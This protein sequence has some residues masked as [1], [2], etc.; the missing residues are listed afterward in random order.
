LIRALQQILQK[1]ESEIGGESE[2]ESMAPSRRLEG[3]RKG[4]IREPRV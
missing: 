3:R 4:R 1:L 2:S